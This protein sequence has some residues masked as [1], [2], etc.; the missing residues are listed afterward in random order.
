MT[1]T[2]TNSWALAATLLVCTAP[3]QAIPVPG[4]GTWETTLQSRDINGDGT[5]DAYYDTARNITWLANPK[6]GAG[7]PF[8]DGLNTIDGRMSFASA[9][10]WL[11]SLDVHGV[12][13]W[14]FGHEISQ[15]FYVT[16]GNLGEPTGVQRG[17]YNTGPF[18]NVPDSS[19]NSGWYWNGTPPGENP[20]CDDPGCPLVSTV[21]WADGV[22]SG[23]Y[24]DIAVTSSMSVWAVHD[25]DVPVIAVPEPQTWALMLG[26]LGLLLAI[27]RR[28]KAGGV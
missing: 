20:A 15:L 24:D 13:D 17:W 2:K 8:D 23:Y 5:V 9:S 1:P 19:F 28:R 16:L 14:R 10:N 11:A 22:G 26:G 27:A 25:G 21:F 4:M 18:I 7:S 6:L 3:A 12:T